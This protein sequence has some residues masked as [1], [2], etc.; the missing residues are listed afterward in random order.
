[1][2]KLMQRLSLLLQLQFL[3]HWSLYLSDSCITFQDVSLSPR[4]L[5]MFLQLLAA[6]PTIQIF[7]SIKILSTDTYL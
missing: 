1:M 6:L 5:K 7:F 3:I 2:K 4:H